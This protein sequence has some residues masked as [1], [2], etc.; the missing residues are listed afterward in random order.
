MVSKLFFRKKALFL[1]NYDN[2]FSENILEI[3]SFLKIFLN[4]VKSAR[5]G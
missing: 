5:S 1:P 3:F 2:I 4:K